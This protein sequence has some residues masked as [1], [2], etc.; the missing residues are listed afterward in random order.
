MHELSK[1]PKERKQ[2]PV[3]TGVLDYFPLAIAAVARVSKKGNDKHNPGQALH[4]SRH[5]S[6]DHADCIGRHLAERD[7]VNEESGELHCIHI[8]WRAL[9][10]AQLAEEK[11]LNVNAMVPIPCPHSLP[12]DEWTGRKP[13]PHKLRVYL[14]GPM[15]GYKDFNFPAFDDAKKVLEHKGYEVVSPADI[16]RV[17]GHTD[18]RGYA[19]RDVKEI[20]TCDMIY[21]LKGWTKSIGATAE[22]MIARW[23]QLEVECQNGSIDPLYDLCHDNILSLK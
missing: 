14:A 17:K 15:R 3:V 11:R 1:N 9:A 10:Y 16:D 6:T 18:N 4:W 13:D 19:E 2:T 12:S 21:L 22:F 8:A 5:L 7:L 20:L 23:I